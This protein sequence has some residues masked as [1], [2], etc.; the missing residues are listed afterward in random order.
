MKRTVF[1][2]TGIVSLLVVIG[3]VILLQ[4]PEENTIPREDD[5][6][7]ITQETEIQNQEEAEDPQ[8]VEE[9]SEEVVVVEEEDNGGATYQVFIESYS[10]SPTG[11]TIKAGDY[12]LWINRDNVDHNVAWSGFTGPLIKKGEQYQHKFEKAG[13]YSYFCTPHPYMTGTVFVEAN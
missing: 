6:Q 12:V 2:I 1:I 8:P 3:T 7:E 9:E 4:K 13:T 10:Y 5:N 11:V